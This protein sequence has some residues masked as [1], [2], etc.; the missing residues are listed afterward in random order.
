MRG[1]AINQ[2]NTQGMSVR[3]GIVLGLSYLILSS[4]AASSVASAATESQSASGGAPQVCKPSE[5]AGDTFAPKPAFAGQTRAP[6]RSSRVSFR[7][8]VVANG[9]A[10]PW[11]LAF[12]PDGRLLV[13]D[14][15]GRLRIVSRSGEVSPPLSGVPSLTMFPDGDG[16][17]HDILLDPQFTTNRILYFTTNELAP[18]QVIEPNNPDQL[19]KGIGRIMRARLSLDA[20]RLEDLRTLHEGKGGARRLAF[21][22]DGTLIATF[23]AI[24]EPPPQLFDTDEGKIVRIRTNGSIPNDN[25]WVGKPGVNP[26]LYAVGIRDAEGL[27]LDRTTG[28]LWETEHGPRGG[29]ELNVIWP[30]KNYGY[31]VITYGREYSGDPINGGLSAKQG[32]E[33]PVYFWTPDIAPSGLLIYRGSMFPEWRGSI[34]I[35]ALAAKRLVRLQ[36]N[37][38]HVVAEEALLSERCQRIRDVRQGPEGAIYLLTDEDP[39]QILRL[40]G[41]H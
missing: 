15:P 16:G 12:L 19:L 10:R 36:L 9:L 2:I 5:Y 8:E 30:G 37:K 17:V 41:T 33:Q 32:M 31:P 25:P 26:E 13:A 7:V 23:F 24:D 28:V 11:A 22:P 1:A 20:R 29:D 40:V 38:G 27:A 21:A 6:A 14:R 35:G 4:L 18:G 3:S 34:F 39:G